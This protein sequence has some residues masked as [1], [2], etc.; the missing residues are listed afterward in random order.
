MPVTGILTESLRENGLCPFSL[1]EYDIVN[2]D[3]S[4]KYPQNNF[5]IEVNDLLEGNLNIIKYILSRKRRYNKGHR[6]PSSVHIIGGWGDE[7][8]GVVGLC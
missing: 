4:V 3:K 1:S 2:I 7:K 8:R 5:E 6:C